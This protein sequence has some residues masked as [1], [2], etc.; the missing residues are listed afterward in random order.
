MN[1]AVWQQV[2]LGKGFFEK[3]QYY[4]AEECLRKV[5]EGGGR[6]ADVFFMLGMMAHERQALKEAKEFFESAIEL[7][8]SYADAWL[9]LSL[10]LGELGLYE[11]AREAQEKARHIRLSPTG[12]IDAYVKQKIANRYSEIGEILTS[13][14]WFE[15]GVAEYQ[16]ALD[17]CPEFVDIRLKLANAYMEGGDREKALE[18]LSHIL[19]MQADYFPARVRYGLV[20]YSLDRTAEAKAAWEYVLQRSPNHRVAKMYMNLIEKR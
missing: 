16:R 4:E 18:E 19:Q 20:L 15:K 3:N 8:A 5:V 1:E 17:L 14:G 10:T 12:E 2:A 6:Y 11:E 7:N 9:G 13:A